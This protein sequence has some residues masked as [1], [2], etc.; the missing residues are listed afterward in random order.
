[1]DQCKQAT[2]IKVGTTDLKKL[3]TGKY[4]YQEVC[5]SSSNF[6]ETIITIVT[7]Q[8][9]GKFK[10]MFVFVLLCVYRAVRNDCNERLK[11]ICCAFLP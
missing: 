5:I 6:I 9:S 4:I 7:I 10:F 8:F 2:R 11:I 1:M 3:P